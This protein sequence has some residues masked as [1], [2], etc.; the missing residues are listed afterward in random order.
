M[1]P[2]DAPRGE[3]VTALSL[4]ASLSPSFNDIYNNY[5]VPLKKADKLLSLGADP[6]LQGDNGQ[7]FEHR[8]ESYMM[9]LGF[10]KDYRFHN[11]AKLP[12]ITRE[13]SEYWK[14]FVNTY[15]DFQ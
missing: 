14:N 9:E 4:F 3:Q 2:D 5:N 10:E 7:T 12:N 6:F 13:S 11:A 8:F 1:Y 15:R